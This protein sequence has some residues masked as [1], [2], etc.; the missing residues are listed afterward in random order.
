M[1]LCDPLR[2]CRANFI[3]PLPSAGCVCVSGILQGNVDMLQSGGGGSF[4]LAGSELRK[5]QRCV[6]NWLGVCNSKQK[7]SSI[8]E[9]LA[10]RS[11]ELQPP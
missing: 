5:A 2:E 11:T 4:D 7:H 8:K 3:F 1:H 9:R 10:P 6:F